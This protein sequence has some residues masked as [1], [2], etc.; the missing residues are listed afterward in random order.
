MG[1]ENKIKEGGMTYEELEAKCWKLEHDNQRAIERIQNFID[2]VAKKY[3]VKS[4][5]DFTCKHTRAL[6]ETI[7]YFKCDNTENC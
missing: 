7:E 5:T 1:T 6:A 3:G 2:F 4:Y